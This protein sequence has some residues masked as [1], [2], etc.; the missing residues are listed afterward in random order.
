M[1]KDSSAHRYH[2]RPTARSTLALPFCLAIALLAGTAS[3]QAFAEEIQLPNS[4]PEI[5]RTADKA[6]ASASASA[7]ASASANSRSDQRSGCRSEASASARV[8]AD[9][10]RIHREDHDSASSDDGGCRSQAHAEAHAD[11]NSDDK[12]EKNKRQD[13]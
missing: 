9:G 11:G 10:K 6:S 8:E 5:V 1:T 12:D 7:K 4:K 13:D 2:H 3:G